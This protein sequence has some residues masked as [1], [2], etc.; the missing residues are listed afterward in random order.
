MTTVAQIGAVIRE[1]R[2]R[3]GL[4]QADLALL[5]GSGE[6]FVREVE[7]GKDTVR[8]GQL[9]EVLRALGIDVRLDMPAG[10]S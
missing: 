3:Q 6:R 10:E 4:R 1:E 7:Q 2:R 9:L 8:A 5:A